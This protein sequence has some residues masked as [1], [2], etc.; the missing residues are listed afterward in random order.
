MLVPGIATITSQTRQH[1]TSSQTGLL[2]NNN[3]QKLQKEWDFTR[4]RRQPHKTSTK[5][6][7]VTYNKIYQAQHYFMKILQS[8]FFCM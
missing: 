3:S 4:S 7:A 2:N 6:A 1:T 5:E 8:I